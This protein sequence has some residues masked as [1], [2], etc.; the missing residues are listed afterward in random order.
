MAIYAKILSKIEFPETVEVE[1]EDTVR[2]T[3]VVRQV[4]FRECM[5]QLKR[6]SLVDLES[7]EPLE[8]VSMVYAIAKHRA[9]DDYLISIGVDPSL[10]PAEGQEQA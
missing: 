2:G 1:I 6:M 7:V 3:K 4:N 5:Q 10:R 8:L 9:I